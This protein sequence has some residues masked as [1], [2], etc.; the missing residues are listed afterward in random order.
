MSLL[1]LPEW[2]KPFPLLDSLFFPW[3]KPKRGKKNNSNRK[4]GS[5]KQQQEQRER[6]GLRDFGRKPRHTNAVLT[7]S[8]ASQEAAKRQKRRR[9]RVCLPAREAS[10]PYLDRR[11][12]EAVIGPYGC[13]KTPT[14]AAV[15]DRTSWTVDGPDRSP[16]CPLDMQM[17]QENN[18]SNIIIFII[19][20]SSIIFIYHYWKK[21]R[22]IFFCDEF[23][24]FAKNISEKGIFCCK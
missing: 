15:R 12:R 23:S 11:E 4:R 24:H 1:Q 2:S 10:W 19:I 5:E 21:R 16:P 8:W 17:K 20:I 14:N 18:R 6:I 22:R 7:C 3:I 13:R 9:G